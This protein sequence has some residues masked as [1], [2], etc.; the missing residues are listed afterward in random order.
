MAERRIY[1]QTD[2]GSKAWES[3]NS[4]LPPAYRRILDLLQDAACCDDIL[5]RMPECRRK[6]VQDWLDELETLCFIEA[7]PFAGARESAHFPQAA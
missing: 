1:R 4:G 6:Q 7:L 5:T 3:P 2:T